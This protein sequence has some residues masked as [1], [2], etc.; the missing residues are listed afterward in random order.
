M[1]S[2]I[3]TIRIYMDKTHSSQEI[4]REM[5]KTTIKDLIWGINRL[6]RLFLSSHHIRKL[7]AEEHRPRPIQNG[8]T[9]VYIIHFPHSY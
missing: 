2:Q 6:N 1:S 4:F 8:E 9:F 7:M 3:L 5:S